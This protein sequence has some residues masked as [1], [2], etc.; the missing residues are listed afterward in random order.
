MFFFLRTPT[1][2][3]KCTWDLHNVSG[4]IDSSSSE[5]IEESRPKALTF[6]SLEKHENWAQGLV[7]KEKTLALQKTRI[8]PLRFS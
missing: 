3:Y 1:G 4:I 6:P 8:W 2:G 7:I 5:M